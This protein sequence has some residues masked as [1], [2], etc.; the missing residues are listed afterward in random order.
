[1]YRSFS[2]FRIYSAIN[3]IT[4]F[5]FGL[6]LAFLLTRFNYKPVV[7]LLESASLLNGKN[8][9]FGKENEEFE[10]LEC[11][12]KNAITEKSRYLSEFSELRQARRYNLIFNL[13]NG[14]LPVGPKQENLFA[15]IEEK[16]ISDRFAVM[17]YEIE[18][19]NDDVFS[20]SSAEERPMLSKIILSNVIEELCS[21]KNKGY[22]I[23]VDPNQFVCVVNL[24]PETRVED[25]AEISERALRFLNEKMGILC[26]AGIGN[27]YTV[28][29]DVRLSY[30]E[31]RRAA[32]YKIILGTGRVLCYH[33]FAATVGA[34][35]FTSDTSAPIILMQCIKGSVTDYGTAFD[36]IYFHCFSDKKPGTPETARSFIFDL[37]VQ[38]NEVLGE[39]D[40]QNNASLSA[41][42]FDLNIETYKTL[43]GFR[44]YFIRRMTGHAVIENH[45]NRGTVIVADREPKLPAGCFNRDEIGDIGAVIGQLLQHNIIEAKL[46]RQFDQLTVFSGKTHA[47]AAEQIAPFHVGS[48]AEGQHDFNHILSPV[49]TA[50]RKRSDGTIGKPA[51]RLC[52][53][54]PVVAHNRSDFRILQRKANAVNLE[55]AFHC[56]AQPHGMFD[57]FLRNRPRLCS[58]A[59]AAGPTELFPQDIVGT[60]QLLCGLIRLIVKRELRFVKQQNVGFLQ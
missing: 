18:E 45:A 11:I 38:T 50:D 29:K 58:R 27:P 19:W 49:Q 31:A 47:K 40:L 5:L 55:G 30:N 16:L 60:Q 10:Y 56:E 1:M 32:E 21:E 34:Y 33:N 52:G 13:I 17:L 37:C 46:S 54:C 43:E 3:L 59:F 23:N 8:T 14:I 25:L 15:E 24:A 4:F 36:K 22:V 26:T 39:L 44:E 12:M 41:H 28:L 48:A 53:N 9:G 7:H 2:Y 42:R 6:L 20:Q 35:D 57:Y 51:V